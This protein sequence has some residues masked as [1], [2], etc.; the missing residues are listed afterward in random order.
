M[1]VASDISKLTYVDAGHIYRY[2]GEAVPHITGIVPSDYSMVPPKVLAH[3]SWR[4]SQAH[5]ATEHY[6]RGI[7][8]WTRLHPEVEPRLE[9]WINA[10]ADPNLDIHFDQGAI[11]PILFHPIHKY[12]GRGDRAPVPGADVYVRGELSTIEIKTIATMDERV[13]YQLS[14]QELI[15]NY[16]RQE[17]GLPLATG[18]WGIQLRDNGKPYPVKYEKPSDKAVFLAHLTL[19]KEEVS[20]GKKTYYARPTNSNGATRQR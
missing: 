14:G 19:L 4:G 17:A 5:E 3:A 12:A 16:L 10:L 13:G 8:D 15:V 9:A 6:D 20:L 11:E 2:D 18:R 1:I 7:L